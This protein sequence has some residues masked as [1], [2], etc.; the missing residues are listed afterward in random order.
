[1]D[2]LGRVG[3]WVGVVPGEQFRR[4]SEVTTLVRCRAEG[5]PPWWLSPLFQGYLKRWL[6]RC[7]AGG[8][9]HFTVI[10]GPVGWAIRESLIW[11][12]SLGVRRL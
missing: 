2:A 5:S 11:L 10:R 3:G 1:M 12:T 4:K 9:S 7:H 8:N 6:G